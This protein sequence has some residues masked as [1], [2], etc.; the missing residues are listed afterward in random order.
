MEAK[1]EIS[2][3]KSNKEKKQLIMAAKSGNK[4][5]LQKLYLDNINLIR[6]VALKYKNNIN[7]RFDFDD[8]MQEAYI[9][10]VKAINNYDFS[11]NGEFSTITVICM[12]NN[13][14]NFLRQ[15]A[16]SLKITST[17]VDNML[18]IRKCYKKLLKNNDKLPTIE[19]V[20][21]K[22]KIDIIEIK[23]IQNTLEF[24][25]TLDTYKENKSKNDFDGLYKFISQNEPGPEEI[26]EQKELVRN[27][28]LFL[29]E[30]LVPDS[31]M[32]SYEELNLIFEFG[33]LYSINKKNPTKS[34]LKE[35]NEI[36]NYLL[37]LNKLDNNTDINILYSKYRRIYNQLRNMFIIIK[38]YGL[39]NEESLTL[40]EIGLYLGITQQRVSNIEINV[41]KNIRDKIFEQEKD[42]NKNNKTKIKFLG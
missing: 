17:F 28:L 2:K 39:F 40:R 37:T 35:M 11:L 25:F 1:Q 7:A 32:Y 33:R 27:T 6:S 16:S 3:E 36:F 5:A 42:I 31:T 12:E 21:L 34:S 30:N 9:G 38:R 18:K 22:T 10:F 26:L 24:A 8:L 20:S 14:K 19:E 15:N 23:Q 13:I 29:K 41:L 4:I